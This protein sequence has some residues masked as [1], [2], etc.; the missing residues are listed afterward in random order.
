MP[1]RPQGVEPGLPEHPAQP[2]QGQAQQCRGIRRFDGFEESDPESLGL[3]A[4]GTAI[5]ALD[6]HVALHP[7]PF[8]VQKTH[9]RRVDA[10]EATAR[11]PVQDHA[12]SVKGNRLARAVQELADSGAAVARLPEQSPVGRSRLVRA[13]DDRIG[14]IG[15]PANPVDLGAGEP[16]GEIAGVFAGTGGFVHVGRQGVEFEVQPA[17]QLPAVH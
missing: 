15:G 5:G 10:L 13:D 9:A 6:V 17:E 8:E 14:D 3:E 7:R 11:G 12:G 2:D 16:D 4:A 1:F